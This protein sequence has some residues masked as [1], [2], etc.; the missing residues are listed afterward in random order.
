MENGFNPMSETAY[1]ILLSLLVERHGYG[2]MQYVSE[3]TKLRINL[4]AGTIYGTLGKL[5]KASLI[6][7][8]REAEK[9]KYYSITQEG[10]RV[11]REEINR[12]KELYLNG[13]EGFID[14][15]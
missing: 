9:R 11:L 12:I 4:G 13:L 15:E 6:V 14:E 8:T 1:Y 5:E 2:I 10:K 3:L 7:M